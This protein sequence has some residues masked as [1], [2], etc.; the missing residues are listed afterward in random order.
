MQSFRQYTGEILAARKLAE[1]K[2]IEKLEAA[3]AEQVTLCSPTSLLFDALL[4]FR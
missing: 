2:N 3:S 1:E 4:N